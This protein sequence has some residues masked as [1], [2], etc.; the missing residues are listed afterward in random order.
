[1]A[2][3]LTA[4]GHANG[5]SNVAYQPSHEAENRWKNTIRPYSEVDVNR[6]RG[7]PLVKILT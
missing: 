3:Q 5:H 2:P 1:M 6:L 7:L 4:N